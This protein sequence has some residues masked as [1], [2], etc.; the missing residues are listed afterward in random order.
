MTIRYLRKPGKLVGFRADQHAIL[1]A[2]AGTGKTYTLEHLVL[3][4]LI[5]ERIAIDQILV[6]T[7]TRRATAELQ[8]R[9]R[10]QLASMLLPD[11]GV[12]Q[13]SAQEQDRYWT[14][15]DEARAWLQQ[16]LNQFDTAQIFTIHSF[17]QNILTGHAFAN[18]QLFSGKLVDGDRLFE[19]T[20]YEILRTVYARDPELSRWLDVWLYF[21]PEGADKIIKDL[22]K[23]VQSQYPLRPAF[24][25][26]EFEELFETIHKKY[27]AKS[28]L[29]GKVAEKNRIKTA[30]LH[31]FRDAVQA[32]LK[33]KKKLE[34]MFTYDD[35]LE[36]VH[37]TLYSGDARSDA[38]L[39]ALRA[40]YKY[41][42]VD[43]FQDTDR[44]QWE[45]FRRIFVESGGQNILCAIGDPKQAIYGFRGADV[46]TY[47]NAIAALKAQGAIEI[48]LT[49][50]FRSSPEMIAAYNEIFSESYFTEPNQYLS[51]V[52]TGPLAEGY[53]H[54]GVL[55]RDAGQQSAAIEILQ[56]NTDQALK[57]S[58]LKLSFA[59]GIAR[60]IREILDGDQKAIWGRYKVA[61]G[62]EKITA[63]DIYVLTRSRGESALIGKTLRRHHIPYS[64]YR[65]EG[66][67]QTDEARHIAELL[68]AICQPA[69]RSLRLRAYLTP[70]FGIPL[71]LVEKYDNLEPS[72]SAG[73]TPHQHLLGWHRLGNARSFRELFQ[74]ILQT[75]GIMRRELVVGASERG[76][77][78]YQHLFEILVR[79]TAEMPGTLDDLTGW[80]KRLVDEDD[81]PELEDGSLQRLET[82]KAAVQ[83]M[84]I[85]KSKGLQAKVVFVFGGLVRNNLGPHTYVE[86]GGENDNPRPKAMCLNH[87]AFDSKGTPEPQKIAEAYGKF[88]REEAERLMYVALTRA[89][90]LMVLPYI[91]GDLLDCSGDYQPVM[92]RL[93]AIVAQINAGTH[94]PRLFK[95]T[96]CDAVQSV[97]SPK[98]L[99]ASDLAGWEIPA[100]PELPDPSHFEVLRRHNT[101]TLASYSSLRQPAGSDRYAEEHDDSEHDDEEESYEVRTQKAIEG[102]K[103]KALIESKIKGTKGG[104]LIHELLEFVDFQSFYSQNSLRE[105]LS[106]DAWYALPATHE[107][108]NKVFAKNGFQ[109]DE[110]TRLE[111]AEMVFNALR[112]PIA[113]PGSASKI[114]L[115]ELETYV[116]EMRFVFPIPE[117]GHPP[118]G[119]SSA[120]GELPVSRGYAHGFIDFTFE[121]EGKTY[122][123]D[124]KSDRLPAGISGEG[125][126]PEALARHVAEKYPTQAVIYT[127][128]TLR[129]LGITK[130]EEFNE[131]F[132][133][134]FYFFA[135]GMNPQNP[136]LGVHFESV[137]WQT[138]EALE[139]HLRAAGPDAWKPILQ[140]GLAG[141]TLAEE[142]P[143]RAMA[144]TTPELEEI[145]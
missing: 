57:S 76:L 145:V 9:I 13:I 74:D 60:R 17:C 1:D 126:N 131:K 41:A 141:I 119:Q 105:P 38:L 144:E 79:Q 134:F 39:A 22:R 142:L 97:S 118:L 80:F 31:K 46:D 52:Q 59:E 116:H 86:P 123:A 82:E 69:E 6:V 85:H 101:L 128:A 58:Q 135:R 98:T 92:N 136:E 78:N 111:A 50:N 117:P 109:P 18:H 63:K 115:S 112:T 56:I 24:D 21:E 34:G 87:N 51:P 133:G 99:E 27:I 62:K 140:G 37:D 96:H 66:L 103:Q 2:S 83:V 89:E 75:S 95:R 129:M 40:R 20:Y 73:K 3:H 100:L 10:K 11:A 121:H 91:P 102:I 125:Y 42:L 8:E 130:K 67:F 49:E 68:A 12:A 94:D 124:W 64:F 113:L 132:G 23:V 93:H 47:F 108:L 36:L 139:Q 137:S 71:E 16:N 110:D 143:K 65:E 25:E 45:V 138:V 88:K 104:N 32:A 5:E 4:L 77:T 28:H 19:E 33:A 29:P 26:D 107:L 35:M 7:F 54:A 120:H 106:F 30:V 114:C 127:M 44:I 61:G 72:E 70:F 81:L 90:A 55:F 53:E 84:T 122:F 43:E 48:Q 14:L 15:D